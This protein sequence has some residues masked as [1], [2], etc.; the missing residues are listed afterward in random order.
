MIKQGKNK[1]DVKNMLI[2]D[3]K[4]DPTGLPMRASL[5]GVLT[6]MK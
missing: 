1:D 2:A 6:E 4:W 3:Y 5:D